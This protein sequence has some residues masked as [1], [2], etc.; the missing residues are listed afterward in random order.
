[1]AV[2]GFQ[3]AICRLIAAN[4]LERREAAESKLVFHAGSIRG[5]YPEISR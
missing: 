1:M 3:Q 4:R 2:T 5:A